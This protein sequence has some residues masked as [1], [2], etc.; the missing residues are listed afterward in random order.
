V[1]I[2]LQLEILDT[3]PSPKAKLAKPVGNIESSYH[4][5]ILATQSND[6]HPNFLLASIL[7]QHLV[8]VSE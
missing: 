2:L 4:E 1:P 7:E 6:Q 3:L 5:N 8:K